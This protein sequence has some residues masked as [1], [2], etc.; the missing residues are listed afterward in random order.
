MPTERATLTVGKQQQ[1]QCDDQIIKRNFQP[2][3]RSEV[4]SRQQCQKNDGVRKMKAQDGPKHT[5][6]CEKEKN[7]CIL[8]CTL[9]HVH[10]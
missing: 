6:M 1:T 7:G 4:Q 9:Q 2:L 3:H 10:H 8:P 5:S